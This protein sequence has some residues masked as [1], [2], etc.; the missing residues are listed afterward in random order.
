MSKYMGGESPPTHFLPIDL[1]LHSHDAV[2]RDN[3]SIHSSWAPLA[4]VSLAGPPQSGEIKIILDRYTQ[5]LQ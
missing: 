2:T 1:I 3:A 5:A 4:L